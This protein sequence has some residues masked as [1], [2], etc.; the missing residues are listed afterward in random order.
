M[1]LAISLGVLS[2]ILEDDDPEGAEWFETS[3]AAANA[4]LVQAGLP[5]HVEPRSLELPEGRASIDGFPYS[6]IHYVRRVYAHRCADPTWMASPLSEDED[7]TDDPVL[8]AEGDMLRSHLLCHS[9]AEGFYLPVDF[10]DVFFAGEDSGL[11][12][13]MLGSSFRLLD[14]LVVAAPALGIQLNA[15]QL[16]DEEAERID[17]LACADEGLSREY[18]SW[19]SLYEAAR[20]S[21]AYKTAIVFC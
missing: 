11:P 19:L 6:F 2:E 8:E 7:P 9:D 15:G 3:L 14:E 18:C 21:I 1:G 4:L 17:E 20:L 5:A 12:G 10:V 16:S 13:G